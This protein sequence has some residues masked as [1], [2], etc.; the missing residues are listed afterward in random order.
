M[1]RCEKNSIAYGFRIDKL[2]RKLIMILK[3]TVDF[4]K[5]LNLERALTFRESSLKRRALIK[6]FVFKCKRQMRHAVFETA[7]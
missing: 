6:L 1:L 7:E 2:S 5:S 3:T 4:L